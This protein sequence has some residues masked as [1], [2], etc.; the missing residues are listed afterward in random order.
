MTNFKNTLPQFLHLGGPGQL[1]SLLIIARHN[2]C[3]PILIIH[4]H[5][6]ESYRNAHTYNYVY[7]YTYSCNLF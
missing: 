6:V 1:H 4:A 3:T 7:T 5:V 2:I